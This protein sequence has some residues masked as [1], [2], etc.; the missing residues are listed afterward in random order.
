VDDRG[1]SSAYK[2]QEQETESLESLLEDLDATVV[3]EQ[4]NF[5][6]LDQ[7][8][9]INEDDVPGSLSKEP[10]KAKTDSSSQMSRR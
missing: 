5:E 8:I 6:A 7:T 3:V 2:D 9:T 1:E 4:D 10:V